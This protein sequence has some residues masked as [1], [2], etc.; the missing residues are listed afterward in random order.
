MQPV[1]LLIACIQMC[2]VHMYQHCVPANAA[3]DA[4]SSAPTQHVPVGH[5]Q[6]EDGL[7]AHYAS[8]NETGTLY[9][10]STHL[11]ANAE[12]SLT[13]GGPAGEAILCAYH[14]EVGVVQ[15]MCG[16]CGLSHAHCN[17][18]LSYAIYSRPY[19]QSVSPGGRLD[20][21]CLNCKLSASLRGVHPRSG[22]K[23]ATPLAL[24]HR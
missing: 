10:T 11:Q 9:P 18:F 23:T 14:V 3:Q 13:L 20:S 5:A 4:S 7:N 2:L 24:R 15:R 6:L 21:T 16:V 17:P 8:R 12:G 19:G 1:C 22:H